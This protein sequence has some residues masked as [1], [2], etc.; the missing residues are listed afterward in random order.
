MRLHGDFWDRLYREGSLKLG[1]KKRGEEKR[2]EAMIKQ[3][4]KVT[5]VC[6]VGNVCF[7]AFLEEILGA[8]SSGLMGG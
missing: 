3:R 5:E 7:E 1:G 4:A 6:R 2:G 8:F